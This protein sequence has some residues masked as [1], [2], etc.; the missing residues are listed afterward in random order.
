MFTSDKGIAHHRFEV[1]RNIPKLKAMDI[2][3]HFTVIV[4]V[5]VSG[6][7]FYFII[8]LLFYLK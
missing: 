4:S 7:T 6:F 5:L 3:L 2:D 1:S 8:K